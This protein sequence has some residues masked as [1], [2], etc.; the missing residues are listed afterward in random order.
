MGKLQLMEIRGSGHSW[1]IYHQ[2]R[3]V[4]DLFGGMSQVEARAHN[5][6]KAAKPRKTRACLTCRQSFESEGPHNRMCDDCRNQ[7][8]LTWGMWP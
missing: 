7:G 3:K 6:E 5:L 8:G 1:A 2:G 4:Q